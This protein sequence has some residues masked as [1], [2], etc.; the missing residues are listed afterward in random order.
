MRR[1]G[2]CR[3][4]QINSYK[5]LSKIWKTFYRRSTKARENLRIF[6]TA[7]NVHLQEMAG[8][9]FYNLWG[10]WTGIWAIM[11]SQCQYVSRIWNWKTRGHISATSKRFIYWQ[12]SQR[13]QQ[14][15]SATNVEGL[16]KPLNMVRMRSVIRDLSVTEEKSTEYMWRPSADWCKAIFRPIFARHDFNLMNF[17]PSGLGRSM[18]SRCI[19]QVLYRTGDE[20]SHEDIKLQI[21]IWGTTYP[22]KLWISSIVAYGRHNTKQ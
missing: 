12:N 19:R 13:S 22:R 5:S 14:I 2:T 4:S 8:A 6:C 15:K 11:T 20:I 3:D 9:I 1:C 16:C 17:I 10:M 7:W 21:L 18:R